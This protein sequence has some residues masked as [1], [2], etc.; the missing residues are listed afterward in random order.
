MV[1]STS[2]HD[3]PLLGTADLQSLADLSNSVSV[4]RNMRWIPVG[5]RLLISLA[6][7]ALAPILPLMLL[8]YPITELTQKFFSN[9]TGM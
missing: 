8:K 4:I 5:K 2:S 9:L 3:E 7:A 6:V 1:G